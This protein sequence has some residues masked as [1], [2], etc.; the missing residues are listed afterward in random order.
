MCF[1][2][3]YLI[4]LPEER[5]KSERVWLGRGW[6]SCVGLLGGYCIWGR[7]MQHWKT[8]DSTHTAF[9]DLLCFLQVI[10]LFCFLGYARQHV[11]YI[12]PWIFP[13]S[14]FMHLRASSTSKHWET[15]V[16]EGLI[17]TIRTDE[18]TA[19]EER[20]SD[21]NTWIRETFEMNCSLQIYEKWNFVMRTFFIA[22]SG[23][24]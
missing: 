17:A 7:I 18:G 22:T 6:A 13:D 4:C 3:S 8:T 9:I 16:K 14:V 1:E 5:V 12:Q 19:P 10:R 24:L 23:I 21:Q 15:M 11:T 20:L 2:H